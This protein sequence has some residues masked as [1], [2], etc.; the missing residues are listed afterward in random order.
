VDLFDRI[1]RASKRLGPLPECPRR[2]VV[3]SVIPVGISIAME[4][5]TGDKRTLPRKLW[6]R[7]NDRFYLVSSD[8]VQNN[9][10][11]VP[12]TFVRVGR[13]NHIVSEPPAL[14]TI[15]WGRILCLNY[16]QICLE[17]TSASCIMGA[18]IH[19]IFHSPWFYRGARLGDASELAKS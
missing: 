1:V 8:V 2:V 17:L 15:V 11:S 19:S 6:E 4:V 3:D 16:Y 14:G 12:T 9:A 13:L 18:L 7:K 5:T 10:T